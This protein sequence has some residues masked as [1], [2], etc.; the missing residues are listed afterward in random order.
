MSNSIYAYANPDLLFYAQNRDN[1]EK[2]AL[3]TWLEYPE[4]SLILAMGDKGLVWY[5]LRYTLHRL[6]HRTRSRLYTAPAHTPH[7]THTQHT[8]NHTPP[9]L[10]LHKREKAPLNTASCDPLTSAIRTA[11]QSWGTGE[12]SVDSERDT[13]VCVSMCV[14]VGRATGVRLKR[15]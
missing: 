7:H 1:G 6:L 14:C 2:L 10:C 3:L 11:T 15:E 13:W 9:I 8:T 5:L 4:I 12:E